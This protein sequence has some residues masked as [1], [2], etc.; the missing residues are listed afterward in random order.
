VLYFVAAAAGALY[1]TMPLLKS[2]SKSTTY[3]NLRVPVQNFT[4]RDF[5]VGRLTAQHGTVTHT[6]TQQQYMHLAVEMLCAAAM[7][8]LPKVA[9]AGSN[10]SPVGS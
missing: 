3:Q 2:R 7:H 5:Q 4:G 9:G 10:S 6:P 8:F 1:V